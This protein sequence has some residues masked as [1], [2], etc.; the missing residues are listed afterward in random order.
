MVCVCQP[1]HHRLSSNAASATNSPLGRLLETAASFS[2]P[3][4][5]SAPAAV[6]S[7]ALRGY[8]TAAPLLLLSASLVTQPSGHAEQKAAVWSGAS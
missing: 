5:P 1:P 6:S 7:A 8:S 2:G 3:A 4:P